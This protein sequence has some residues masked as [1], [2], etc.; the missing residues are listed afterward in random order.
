MC[1]F[2][3]VLSCLSSLQVLFL[4]GLSLTL[5]DDHLLKWEVPLEESQRFDCHP[6]DGADESKCQARGCNWKVSTYGPF[7]S[8][9]RRAVWF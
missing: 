4:R 9:G 5:G 7:Q 8:L 3:P 6:E 2:S 1:V